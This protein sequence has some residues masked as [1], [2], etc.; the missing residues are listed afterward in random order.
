[1]SFDLNINNYNRNELIEMFDLPDNFD[2]KILEMKE[3]KLKN[4]ILIN[5]EINKETQN[6]T[7]NFLDKAKKIILNGNLKSEKINN[8]I[9]KIYNTNFSLKNTEIENKS[10]N[11]HMVQIKQETPYISSLP[12]DIH[13]GVI[14]PLK[15]RTIKQNLNIDTRFRDNY[16]TS[17][18]TNYNLTLPIIFS[19]VVSMQLSAI[20]LPCTYYS[21]SKQY[22]N[23]FFTLI[24]NGNPAIINIPDGNYSQLNIFQIIEEQ[25]NTFV[26]VDP[27]FAHVIFTCN[28]TNNENG[29]GQTIVGFNGEQTPNATLELNFQADRFGIQDQNTPLPLK[30]GWLLGFRNGLYVNNTNYVSES[31]LDITGPRYLYLVVDDH[32]NSVTNN[33][34]S[35]FNSSILNKNILARIS[36]QAPVFN[37]LEQNNLNIVTIP[38]DY[39]GPVNLQNL[40]IQLLDEYGRNVDLN[41]MDFSFCLNLT[42]IYDL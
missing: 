34:Y 22:G 27:D 38:R 26:I 28:L 1:M 5:Q 39:F 4:S 9:E 13:P 25:I 15:R 32:N 36:L 24:V 23:N 7:I 33:F 16:Y 12:S 37:I 21:V 11:E 14:N 35:A 29:S 17:S 10:I 18:A 6:K 41:Y 2:E 31:V 3:T 19:K 8:L 30:F 20:E 40:N 42:C